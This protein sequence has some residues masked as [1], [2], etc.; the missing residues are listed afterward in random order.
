MSSAATAKT[1]THRAEHDLLL[2][3]VR[4]DVSPDTRAHLQSLAAGSIDWEYL[5]LLARRH[6]VVSLLYSRLEQCAANIVPAETLRR[7]QK[8][9]RENSARNVLLSAELCRLIEVFAGAGIEAIP[10]KG[11]LLAS[12]AYDN[13]ALRRFV[14]LDII[15]RRGDVTR[16]IDVLRTDG[17]ELSKLLS[18]SQ[19]QVLL[20]TQHNVQ[21]RRDQR[22]L[23]VELHWE[24]ASHLFASS[25]QADD[26]W[27]DLV[28]VELNGTTLRTLSA[29]DLLF[30]LSVHG[31]RHLWERLSWICDVGWIMARHE[32]NWPLLLSRAK[33]TSTERMFLLGLSLAATLLDVPLPNSVKDH[34]AADSQLDKLAGR[35]I[36][37]L[38]N[39]TDHAPA[40]S[41]EIF[42]YNFMVR[43]SWQARA[44]YCRYMLAPTDRDLDMISLPGPLSFGYYLMRPLRL[45]F[46]SGDN[47]H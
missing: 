46:K 20:R 16:A 9:F 7:L 24:V 8:Y 33:T 23:I 39:S 38:F 30:S 12:F 2:Y 21:F 17:Y 14:D 35:V 28:A 26:L 25:V 4:P 41:A 5:F 27:R 40:T 6:A 32:L 1:V 3:S 45:L 15:V 19:Q 22:R 36:Q 10:Y 18:A 42:R 13:V 34:V 37:R 44:R 29:D 47:V 43:K 31:S 11:P